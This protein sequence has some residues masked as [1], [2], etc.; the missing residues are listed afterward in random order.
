M[1]RALDCSCMVVQFIVL[2]LTMGMAQS[3]QLDW[4]GGTVCVE[5]RSS[6]PTA[7]QK[8]T[9]RNGIEHNR[10][11]GQKGLRLSMPAGDKASSRWGRF[12]LRAKY[13]CQ[14]NLQ[15]S[16]RGQIAELRVTVAISIAIHLCVRT[17][18]SVRSRSSST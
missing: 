8:N 14:S 15:R 6:V 16:C 4:S 5:I 18:R 11:K 1:G 10:L 17:T 13:E 7:S 2:A 9:T 12:N 3:Q